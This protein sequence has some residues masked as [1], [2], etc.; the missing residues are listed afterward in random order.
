MR[1]RDVPVPSVLLILLAL[2]VVVTQAPFFRA[3]R[4]ISDDGGGR[5]TACTKD[6]ASCDCDYS[7]GKWVRSRSTDAMP[8]GEDCPFLDPGF[9]CVQN[10]R[11]DSSFRHWRWQPRRGSCHLPKFNATDMLERSRNGRIVF[12]GD[13]IGRNQWESMLCMLAAAV[14]AGSR[15]YEQFGK[16]LSRHKGYLSMVFADYNLSVEYYRAPMLVMVDRLPPAS[17]GAIKRAIRLDALPRHAARWAGADVLILNTGHWWNLHKT[18]KSGNYFTVGDRFNMT[19]DIKEAFRRSLQTVKDWALTNPR[20]SKSSYIFFRS[21][22]PSHYDNGTWDTG[23]SCADQWDPLTMITS[24]SDQHEHL[25]INTMI[26]SA[27]QSMR[28]RHGMNKDAVFLN[29]TY[30]TGMRGDGHPSR[31]REPETPSD[32]PEDC[33][34]WCLPGV[35]DTWNQMMYGHLVSMGFDMRSIKR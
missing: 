6:A 31:H 23:G 30:M 11:N 29:I 5:A 19:T 25:W 34:H 2:S 22:S 10:G 17:D 32:A 12:V 14:P 1:A 20:L 13:S 16:P 33:S 21:Y 27:A 35:P 18:I 26:S 3:R 28:R 8:Y 7:D 4:L 9:R 15:I 24:E